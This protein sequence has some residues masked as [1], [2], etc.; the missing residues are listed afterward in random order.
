M[1]DPYQ[2]LGVTKAAS[3]DD[4][5]KAYRKLAK[6]LHPDL[7][8]GNA[9]KAEQFS[10]VSAAY[11]FLSDADKRARFD[12]GEIDASG[13]EM[14][15][16]PFGGGGAGWA[17]GGGA[18][19]KKYEGRFKMDDMFSGEDIFSELF[20]SRR[21]R[22][23]PGFAG[24]DVNYKLSVSFR[25]AALG[26][27][28]NVRLASGKTLD[29]SIPPGTTDGQK[30][31]LK[32]QG[33]PGQ[34]GGAAGDAFVEITVEP[35]ATLTRKDNDIHSEV[36]VPLRDAVLG[37]S[38]SVDTLDGPVSMKVPKGSNSGTTLRLK[39]KGVASRGGARGDH[40][41]RLMVNVPDDASL[42]KVLE[43]W[44]KQDA[45]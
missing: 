9:K 19:G 33:Q 1:K 15:R 13:A 4:I 16:G 45:K 12:R 30:L 28:K 22:A 17:G 42:R 39:G 24:A 2:V 35:D 11:D 20:G 3:A 23:A 29:L 32:G 6:T 10:E 36:K 21:G 8:P 18:G 26:A 40:F 14:R 5:K 25:E 38:V 27:K 31:R 43:D 7:N 44:A 34:R 37:G 41:V